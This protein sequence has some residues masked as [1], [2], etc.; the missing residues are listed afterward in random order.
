MQ[1]PSI[2]SG[3][4]SHWRVI[5]SEKAKLRQRFD[6]EP[7]FQQADLLGTWSGLPLLESEDGHIIGV[8]ACPRRYINSSMK[9]R[10]TSLGTL[11][12]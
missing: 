5:S 7:N 1:F 11:R 3:L 4:S 2:R 12:S 6:K 10:A 8:T 9:E